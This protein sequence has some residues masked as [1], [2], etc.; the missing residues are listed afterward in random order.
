MRIDLSQ[1][2]PALPENGRIG[3]SSLASGGDHLSADTVPGKDQAEFSGA[4]V[5]VQALA[6]QVLQFPEIREAKVNTLRQVVLGGGY[7]PESSQIAEAVFAHL[8]H[9]PAA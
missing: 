2:A 8:L 9:N 4:R 5:Q 1:G 7:Q 3:N 6:A